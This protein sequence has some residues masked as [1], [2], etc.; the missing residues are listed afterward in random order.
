MQKKEQ[1]GTCTSAKSMPL[2]NASLHTNTDTAPCRMPSMMPVRCSWVNALLYSAT[3]N[4]PDLPN[5][6]RCLRVV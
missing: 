1:E 6:L 5:V 4:V 2:A 3:A